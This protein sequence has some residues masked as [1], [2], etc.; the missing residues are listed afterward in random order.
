MINVEIRDDLDRSLGDELRRALWAVDV[1]RFLANVEQTILRRTAGGEFLE[2]SSPGAESYSTTPFARPAGGLSNRVH[3]SAEN[4]SGV[5]SYFTKDEALWMT[6]GGGYKQL[7][8]L[9]GL[10]TGHVDLYDNGGMLAGLRSRADTDTDGDLEMEVGYIEGLS[11]GRAIELANYHNRLGAGKSE[12][13][14]KFVG[15]TDEEANDILD[16]LEADIQRRL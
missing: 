13:I 5:S 7:R 16:D 3:Q 2:G 15:L 1:A 4:D 8:E 9:K 14:R 11:P 10:P 12:M 6:F